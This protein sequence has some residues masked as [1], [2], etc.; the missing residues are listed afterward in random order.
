LEDDCEFVQGK[1]S[2][3]NLIGYFFEI[4]I[5]WDVLYLGDYLLKEQSTQY[6]KIKRVLKALRTH[7]YVVNGHYMEKL[8]KCF[9]ETYNILRKYP[10]FSQ[11]FYLAIDRS[12][13]KLQSKDKWYTLDVILIKQSKSFSDIDKIEKDR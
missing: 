10:F 4:K 1:I 7:A 13:V 12:W 8:K 11:S 6:P 2:I 3:D 9:K 5:K